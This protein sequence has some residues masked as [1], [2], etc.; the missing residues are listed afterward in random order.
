MCTPSSC[1][2]CLNS[3]EKDN[4]FTTKCNHCFHHKCMMEWLKDNNTCPVCRNELFEKSPEEKERSFE[5]RI[6]PN[7]HLLSSN[8]E[9]LLFEFI[10]NSLE[11]PLTKWDG[12]STNEAYLYAHKIVKWNNIRQKVY[13]YIYLSNITSDN[14]FVFHALI[15]RIDIIR[16]VSF[17]KKLR[18]TNYSKKIQK[19][20][21]ARNY[22]FHRKRTQ[23]VGKR[24]VKHV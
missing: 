14:R 17:K 12:E 2:I 8:H 4:V 21:S 20:M 3:I 22:N 11:L 24:Y 15:P 10:E 19:K 9:D 7:S 23:F 1:T 5:I 6:L 16:E 18:R 13:L